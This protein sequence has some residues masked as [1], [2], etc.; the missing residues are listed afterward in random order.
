MTDHS[1]FKTL[2]SRPIWMLSKGKVPSNAAGYSVDY[3]KAS[4]QMSYE[5][6]L[7]CIGS[8]GIDTI[9]IVT[10]NG[11]TCFDFD[12]CINEEG[13][14][15]TQEANEGLVALGAQA[16]WERSRSGHGLHAF[17]EA[18]FDRIVKKKRIEIYC[19]P[20]YIA[21]TFDY[22]TNP[23][24]GLEGGAQKLYEHYAGKPIELKVRRSIP[25][26]RLD[27]Y[28]LIN[29]CYRNQKFADLFEGRWEKYY[30]SASEADIALLEIIAFYSNRDS[31]AMERIFDSSKLVRD[32]WEKREDYRELTITKALNYCTES[33]DEYKE[34]M[35]AE[36]MQAYA[37]RFFNE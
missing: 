9:G 24:Q 25:A 7:S 36:R 31:D 30:T 6:A 16:L 29:R 3:T 26:S 28:D 5:N 23:P 17:I 12:D 33:I 32:K 21:M 19:K 8:N 22:L 10:G 14:I 18:D 35:S 13:K 20:H 15:C 11:I 4:N 2:T 27:D 34:R 1:M 37:D